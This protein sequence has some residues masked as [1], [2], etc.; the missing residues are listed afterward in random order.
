MDSP[1]RANVGLTRAREAM[2]V[3]GKKAN[4]T[5]AFDPMLKRLAKDM[6]LGTSNN[7]WRK[8]A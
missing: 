2:F 5:K 4:Y 7:Y 8:K 3:V 6:S 1:N